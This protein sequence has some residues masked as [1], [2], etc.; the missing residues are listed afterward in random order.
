LIAGFG[1][2]ASADIHSLANAFEKT[3][4]GGLVDGF[5]APADKIDHPALTA[6]ARRY[7]IPVYAVETETIK[8]TDTLTQ[9]ATVRKWRQTGSVAEAAALAPFTSPAR[10]VCTRQI[11]DDRRAVCAVAEGER[12]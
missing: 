9:S 11:S 8:A 7:E 2:R 6:L 4:T 12:I 3:A 10:L 5:S 1:F